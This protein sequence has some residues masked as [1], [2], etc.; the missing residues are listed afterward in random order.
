MT[1]NRYVVAVLIGIAAFF[2][3]G[4]IYLIFFAGL[5]FILMLAI[6]WL[7]GKSPQSETTPAPTHMKKIAET[8][9]ERMKATL[10][11]ELNQEIE[12]IDFEDTG[13]AVEIDIVIG[14]NMLDA[15]QECVIIPYARIK[16]LIYWQQM[17]GIL[18]NNYRARMGLH[19]QPDPP[20]K[21]R[22]LGSSANS[23]VQ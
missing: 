23:A 11:K 14:G 8:M 9:A 13:V 12:I 20:L 17:T 21:I 1:I 7:N 2:V 5:L 3:P 16:D 6:D 10:V 19:V 4:G 22:K 18:L 15:Y